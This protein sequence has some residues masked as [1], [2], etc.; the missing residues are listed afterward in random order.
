MY[1]PRFWCLI[2]SVALPLTLPSLLHSQSEALPRRR[3]GKTARS[4]P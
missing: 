4:L 3:S 1:Q 2:L